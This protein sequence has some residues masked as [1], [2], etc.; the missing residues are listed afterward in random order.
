MILIEDSVQQSEGL[1]V[2]PGTGW[3]SGSDAVE[4][5]AD[6]WGLWSGVRLGDGGMPGQSGE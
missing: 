3:S 1:R 4:N 5:S 6:A 2:L